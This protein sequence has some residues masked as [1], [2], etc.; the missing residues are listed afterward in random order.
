MFFYVR[1][2]PR[3]ASRSPRNSIPF[4]NFGTG[5]TSAWLADAPRSKTFLEKL[6]KLYKVSPF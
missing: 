5:L 1:F 6:S 3:H 2:L 4:Q